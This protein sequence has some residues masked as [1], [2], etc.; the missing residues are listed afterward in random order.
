MAKDNKADETPAP[1]KEAPK[2]EAPKKEAVEITASKVKMKATKEGAALSHNKWKE[3]T[4]FECHP[5]LANH[6]EERGYAKKV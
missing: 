1:K 6:F 4:E 3:G 5:N 2:K